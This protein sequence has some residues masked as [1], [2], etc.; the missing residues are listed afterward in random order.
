MNSTQKWYVYMHTDYGTPNNKKIVLD[1]FVL[2]FDS[3]HVYLR[4]YRKYIN[5]S[6]GMTTSKRRLKA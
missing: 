1:I 3:A 2:D 4:N 6:V 5:A